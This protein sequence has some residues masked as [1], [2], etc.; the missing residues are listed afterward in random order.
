MIIA[1]EGIDGSGK[2][3]QACHF[4]D[5][6]RGDGIDVSLMSFPRYRLTDFGK[7][8]GEF[9]NGEFGALDQVHPKLAAIPYMLDRW[10]SLGEIESHLTLRRVLVFDR[11]V[12]SNIAHQCAKVADEAKAIELA[13]WITRLEHNVLKLPIP[14]IVVHLDMP[15]QLAAQRM[16][17]RDQGREYTEKVTDIHESDLTYLQRVRD[18]YDRAQLYAQYRH[19]VKVQVATEDCQETPTPDEIAVKVRLTIAAKV[20]F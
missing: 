4:I 14:D 7:V 17:Q 5:R 1:F 2:G 16:A 11:Y 9:L 12:P 19:W 20:R 10:Q 15:V 13:Q 6:L 3:T 18:W 8:V